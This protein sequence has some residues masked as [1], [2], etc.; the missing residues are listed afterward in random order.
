MIR[1]SQDVHIQRPPARVFDFVATRYQ[2]NHPRWE[3][4]VVEIRRL[5]QGPVAL[6]SRFLMVRRDFGRTAEAI[7][8]VVELVPGRRI[9]F[10]HVDAAIDFHIAFNCDPVA[11]GTRLRVEVAAEPHGAMRLAGPMLRLRMPKIAVRNTSRIRD[12]VESEAV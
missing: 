4:E 2:E 8:E 9:A 6:G 1:H 3:Q 5:D 12:L 11:D 7:N 10:R